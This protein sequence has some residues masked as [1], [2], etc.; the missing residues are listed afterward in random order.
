MH[1]TQVGQTIVVCGLPI[2]LEHGRLA[3]DE[4][5]SSAPQGRCLAGKLLFKNR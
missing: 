4:N 3:D 1:L 5:R 2:A